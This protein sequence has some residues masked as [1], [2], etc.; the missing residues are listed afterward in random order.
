MRLLQRYPLPTTAGAANNFTRVGNERQNQNQFDV[1]I[2]HRFSTNSAVFG[3]YSYAKDFSNPVAPL[4]DGSGNITNGAIGKTDTRAGSLVLNYTRIFAPGLLNELRFG[5]TR[6][7]VK[8]RSSAIIGGNTDLLRGVPETAAFRVS[9][10]TVSIAGFQPLGSNAN[11]NTDFS[12]A[13]TEFYDAVSYQFNKHSFK[14][15]GDFRRERLDVLQPPAPTGQFIFNQILTNSAGANGAR[16]GLASLTG[17]AFASF[18]L[19]QVQNFSIDLQSEL[20]RPRAKFTELFAQD[21]WR[22]NS[23][24]TLILGVLYTL[25]FPSTEKNNR[26]AVFNLETQRLDFSRQNGNSESARQLSPENY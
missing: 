8:R 22:I 23:K 2:D 25:N 5:E 19:G 9:L 21:N 10:P 20:L 4:P 12:T 7:K 26:A 11:T 6:R 13:V 14:F 24:L 16:N 15:G 3:R 1:R 18:L 17:N